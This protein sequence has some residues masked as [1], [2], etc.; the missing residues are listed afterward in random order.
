[1]DAGKKRWQELAEVK[2]E[3][4]A[5][6]W[7]PATSGNLSIKVSDDP[8]RFFVTASGKDKRKET[9]EDFLLVDEEGMPAES[10]HTLKPS[11]ETLLHT[12]VYKKTNAG[13]CLH[14][15]TIDNNVISELYGQEKQV[16]FRGQEIIKALG[17][18]EENAEVTVPIIENTAHI[19]DLAA[20]FAAHLTKDSGAVLIRSHGITVWG[21]TAFE[22]KRMLE[23]YEFLFSWH[24]KLK[25]FQTQ[26]A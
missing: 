25:S 22:A 4:A 21:R 10:G 15:H 14:V 5:R 24:L 1:M 7:F 23:A 3:L 26:Y 19:P 6:D 11:A 16:S 9:D 12:Y 17:Y 18:W 20:D 13:C 2:R 8:L